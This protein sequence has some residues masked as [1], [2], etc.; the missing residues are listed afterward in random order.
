MRRQP[1][2]LGKLCELDGEPSAIGHPHEDSLFLVKVES[3][4]EL[5]NDFLVP[6]VMEQQQVGDAMELTSF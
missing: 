2:D 5:S 6:V 4:I 3:G 1:K